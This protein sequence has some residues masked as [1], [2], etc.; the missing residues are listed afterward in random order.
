MHIPSQDPGG[1]PSAPK[2]EW[3]S[4][5]P[6]DET[7]L[8]TNFQLASG[9]IYEDGGAVSASKTERILAEKNNGANGLRM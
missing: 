3:S 1:E 5:D 7:F 2:V 4:T 9:V 8:T 6:E